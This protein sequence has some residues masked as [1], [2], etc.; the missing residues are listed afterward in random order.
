MAERRKNKRTD[1]ASKL[2]IKQID[3]S[4]NREVAINILDVS[5]SGLGFECEDE[6]H[7]GEVYESYLTI[8]T[9]EVLHT[10]L[11]IVRVELRTNGYSYGAVFIGM[12]EM[13]S[14]RIETYQTVREMS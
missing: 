4:A 10:F 8:W 7:I 11:Q 2:M 5:K 13:D 12:G 1:M 3:G 14:A 6:L 9:Q